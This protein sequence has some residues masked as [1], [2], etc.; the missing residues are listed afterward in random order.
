M[1]TET[2]HISEGQFLGNIEPFKSQGLP[3]NSIIHKKLTGCGATTLELEYP[4]NSII[5]EPNVPVIV[6]KCKKMN[7]NK[8]KNKVVQA[9]HNGKD[10]DDIKYYLENRNGYKKILTTPE[11]FWKVAE[12]IGD[13]MYTDYF[14]LFDECEKAIQE[15][16]FRD[17]II[18]PIDA[19]FHFDNKAFVSATPIIPS[20]PRF[21]T[22]KHIVIEPDYDFKDDITVCMTNNIVFHLRQMFDHYETSVE[23]QG[24]KLFIFFKSTSR[25]RNIIINSLKLNDYAVY[26]SEDS[27]KELHR[28]GIHNAYD[29]INDKFS[30][31]NFLTSRFFSAV[32]IDY[33]KY[34]CDPIVIMV[35]D[36]VSVGHSIIDPVTEAIQICGRFR[37]PEKEDEEQGKITVLKDIYHVAN[38]KPKLT[39]FS[40]IEVRAILKDKKKLH[41]FISNFKPNSDIEYINTFI[42]EILKI[43]GFSYFLREKDG[44][45]NHFMVDN[46]V[47]EER[48][49]GYFQTGKSLQKQYGLSEHFNIDESS[50]YFKY[51]LTDEQLL[52]FT[53][54]AS[55][56][57]LNQFVSERVKYILDSNADNISKSLNMAMLRHFYSAQM[58]V[59]D[60]YGLDNA[61]SLDYSIDR[62]LEQVDQAKG[63]SKLLPIIKFI[64]RHFE[65]RGYTSIEIE[66]ILTRGLAETG[67]KGIKPDVKL[68]RNACL[69]SERK[70]VEKDINGTWLKGYEVFG[71]LQN[72]DMDSK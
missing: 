37:N 62:I 17:G 34:K 11:G 36:V 64:Q 66:A 46:F 51:E 23:D 50:R 3:T 25:I 30:K 33:K 14:L 42:D 69:L 54:R 35:S 41:D 70:N 43:N 22:F 28:N 10:V 58:R 60:Q 12:A 9:V 18:D 57:K 6:G 5:I 49:K 48:V 40:E 20:D 72:L 56:V 19:F 65:K 26:C 24:R 7:K 61:A 15:I 59:L 67:L 1:T 21:S 31:Y 8:R 29:E 27:A 2:Y 44:Q 52:E 13:S 55:A 68:L 32:D 4:R 39:S 53:D 16:D 47:N 71:F 45:L 38:Y 63:L